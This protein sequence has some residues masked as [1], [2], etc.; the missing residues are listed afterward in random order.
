M[1]SRFIPLPSHVFHGIPCDAFEV[2]SRG[3]GYEL[4]GPML[5]ENFKWILQHEA[6]CMTCHTTDHESYFCPLTQCRLCISGVHWNLACQYHERCVTAE[7]AARSKEML[8]LA[9]IRGLDE[10]EARGIEV[11][12]RESILNDDAACARIAS[13]LERA[14]KPNRKAHQR[15]KARK[16][17]HR[18]AEASMC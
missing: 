5:A 16:I 2:H 10:A 1:S 9:R 13:L 15:A 12:D 8:R 17:R 11:G 3:S 6:K 7:E 4:N 14:K 18:A